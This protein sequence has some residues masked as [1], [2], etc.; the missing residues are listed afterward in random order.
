MTSATCEH[1]TVNVC[2]RVR[3]ACCSALEVRHL[4]PVSRRR[5]KISRLAAFRCVV[6]VTLCTLK[7]LF[8]VELSYDLY[9]LGVCLLRLFRDDALLDA[10][11][12]GISFGNV[13][14]RGE[15]GD[16]SDVM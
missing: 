1:D 4:R 5:R 6:G 14:D 3:G 12:R 7:S 16:V 2:V 11:R 8:S 13:V 10:R 9:V 15:V